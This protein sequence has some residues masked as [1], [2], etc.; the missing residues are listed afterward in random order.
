MVMGQWA[1]DF[2]SGRSSGSGTATQACVPMT[3]SAT[4]RLRNPVVETGATAPLQMREAITVAFHKPLLLELAQ[5]GLDTYGKARL[6]QL[7]TS[8]GPFLQKHPE[9][10]ALLGLVPPRGCL[11]G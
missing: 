4:E 1:I 3:W 10:A 5:P 11:E 8:E 2:S 6:Q 9:N 7:D